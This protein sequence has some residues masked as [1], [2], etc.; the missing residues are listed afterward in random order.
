MIKSWYV[1]QYKELNMSDWH[2]HDCEMP[3]SEVAHQRI[4]D[5]YRE[6]VIKAPDTEWRII[7]RT[8]TIVMSTL[9]VDV[10]RVVGGR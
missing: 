8:E 5:N 4:L 1:L 10:R 9:K 2:D 7:T 6:S 3:V